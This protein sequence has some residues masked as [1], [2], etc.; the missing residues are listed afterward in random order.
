MRLIFILNFSCLKGPLCEEPLMGCAFVVQDW[1]IEAN[2][3]ETTTSGT[4]GP[5]S[6]QIVSTVKEACRKAF[7]ARPQRLAAAMYTCDIQ[8]SFCKETTKYLDIFSFLCF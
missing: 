6:G 7:Q 8:V 1:K 5:L 2:S 3:T 4:Y